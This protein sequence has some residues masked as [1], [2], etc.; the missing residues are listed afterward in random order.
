MLLEEL[1]TQGREDITRP[2]LLSSNSITE[3]E[4]GYDKHYD[5]SSSPV[6]PQVILKDVSAK[7]CFIL[8]NATNLVNLNFNIANICI[9]SWSNDRV[10][11][12]NVSLN[13]TGN[14]LVMIVGPVGS[15][16]VKHG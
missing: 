8:L 5:V 7:Y 10:T 15:G 9:S 13:L 4:N 2:R 3:K 12:Q 6:V 14:Q 1:K 16:K 11:L